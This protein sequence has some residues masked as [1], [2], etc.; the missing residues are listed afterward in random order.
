MFHATARLHM[1][2][3][4]W[5]VCASARTGHGRCLHLVDRVT[6]QEVKTFVV[7]K[8]NSICFFMSTHTYITLP[9]ERYASLYQISAHFFKTKTIA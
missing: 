3:V 7:H 8:T 2:N 9:V 1:T 6:C 4:G 5:G